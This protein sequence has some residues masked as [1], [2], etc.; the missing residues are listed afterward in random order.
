[1]LNKI[2]FFCILWFAFAAQAE[3]I[4][5]KSK[6]SQ[7]FLKQN[8]VVFKEDV[9]IEIGKSSITAQQVEL[10]NPS[11]P[12]KHKIF[13]TGN[14]VFYRHKPQSEPEMLIKADSFSFNKQ[15]GVYV[16]SGHVYLKQGDNV[17]SGETLTY[18]VDTGDI[19]VS[20]SNSPDSF[21]DS[22]FMVVKKEKE[23]DDF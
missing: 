2:C 23:E 16:L 13:A 22:S 21:V 20:A 14:P 9:L 5:I 10:H 3:K 8:K 4:N 18:R 15:S 7:F 12:D 19:F 17:V 11:T 6:Q 1:M